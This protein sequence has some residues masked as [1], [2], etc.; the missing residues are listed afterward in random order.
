M[1]LTE[2]HTLLNDA[3]AKGA[4][5]RIIG[6]KSAD[7]TVADYVVKLHNESLYSDLIKE[8]KDKLNNLLRSDKEGVLR[9]IAAAVG[10]ELTVVTKAAADIAEKL[11]L[12][13]QSGGTDQVTYALPG[14]PNLDRSGE[15]AITLKN[16]S[17]VSTSKERIKKATKARS[18][19]QDVINRLN[20]I[21]PMTDGMRRFKLRPDSFTRIEITSP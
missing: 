6:Y 18:P 4:N 12:K 5:V 14:E 2:L 9:K 3:R 7:G 21:L 10:V 1:E 8:S 19:E 17:E 11:R 15:D 20:E 16:V 13:L